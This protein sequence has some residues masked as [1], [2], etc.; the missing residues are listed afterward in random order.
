MAGLDPALS[1][2]LETVIYFAIH[3]P[4]LDCL[5]EMNH[6]LKRQAVPKEVSETKILVFIHPSK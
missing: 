1:C 6:N 4:L 3:K 5:H 2:P